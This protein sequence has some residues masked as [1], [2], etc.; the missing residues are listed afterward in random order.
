M[1]MKC[2]KEEVQLSLLL[3]RLGELI[4]AEEEKKRKKERTNKKCGDQNVHDI[5]KRY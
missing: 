3:E 5:I 2:F 4:Q 1:I